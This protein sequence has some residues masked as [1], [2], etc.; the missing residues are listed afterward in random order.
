VTIGANDA[1]LR[2]RSCSCQ[3]PPLAFVFRLFESGFVIRAAIGQT[4]AVDDD[5]LLSRLRSLQIETPSWG[6]GN[7]GTRFHVFPWPGAARDVWERLAD[8]ALVHRLTG[9]CPTVALH[10]PWDRV[11]DWSEL[12]RFAEVQG[13]RI[14]AINPNVFGDDA[15]RLGSLCNPDEAVRRLALEQCLE[16]VEIAGE[17]GSAAISLWL[18][19]GTNYPGQDDL[20]GRYARLTAGLEELYAALPPN[21]RLLVEYKFFEPGFY[22]TDLPD[23]GTAALACRR[24]GSQAQVLVDTGHHPQGTNVE[25]IVALLLAE[26]LLGGFHFNNRKYADDDL[27]V[28]AI[29]PFELFRIM[30][31]IALAQIDPATAGTAGKIAFMIDQSHNIE[32]KIDAMLQSVMNIQTAYAKALLVDEDAVGAAQREGDVLGAH[33]LLVDAFETDVRPL[34]ARLR[35]ELGL[36]ADPVEAFRRQGHAERLAQERGTASVTSAYEQ[37]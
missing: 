12:R 37:L 2:P 30:R 3:Y 24:L 33:R 32:G 20:R 19:D 21:L 22:S 14:G 5:A 26:G 27:I 36:E 25:Q 7:S 29:D 1:T 8:A 16:C 28:G 11:D 23:W 13:V 4:H 10:V 9:C 6:Y 18:A 31:E 15:Y 17:L 35:G 34:L